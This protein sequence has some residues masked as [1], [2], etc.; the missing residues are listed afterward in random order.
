MYSS[1]TW[2]SDENFK[3]IWISSYSSTILFFT[4]KSLPL[5]KKIIST[6]F[7]NK[8]KKERFCLF[9]QKIKYNFWD[10]K[11]DLA[12]R[13]NDYFSL[14][15]MILLLLLFINSILSS[16]NCSKKP[17][18]QKIVLY[19]LLHNEKLTAFFIAILFLFIYSFWENE[20]TWFAR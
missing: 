20:R 10:F 18:P 1:I 2:N 9:E 13:H 8:T 4:V 12:M 17:F 14:T 16:E 19:L 15:S 11:E 6:T 3:S 7:I 5:S